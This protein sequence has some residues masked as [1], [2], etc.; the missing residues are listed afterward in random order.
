MF[1]IL[2]ETRPRRDLAR[3]SRDETETIKIK[4]RGRLEAETSRPRLHPCDFL[5]H[6]QQRVRVNSSYSQWYRVESGIAQGS[7]LGP[8]LF[9]IY[10]NDLIDSCDRNSEWA[11]IY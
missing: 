6:R 1:E 8:I 3:F 2:L 9:L 11:A 4:P 7:I 10:I 5:S